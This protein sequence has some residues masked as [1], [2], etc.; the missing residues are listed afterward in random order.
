MKLRLWVTAEG[1]DDMDLFVALQKLDESGKFLPTLILDEP[2]PGA[3]GLMRVSHRELDERESTPYQP[4]QT[5][6]R[7]QLLKPKEIVPVDIEIYP[8][9]RIWHAGEQLRVVVSGRYLRDGWGWFE[10]FAWDLRNKGDHI[11][12]TGAEYDS[13]LLVP[14]VPPK[15]KARNYVHR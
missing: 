6:R 2:Y 8:S 12:Y 5:H 14:V 9:S 3:P 7:E 10:P 11:I 1:A 15:R 13:H 4:V